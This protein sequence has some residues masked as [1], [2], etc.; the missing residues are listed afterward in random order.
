MARFLPLVVLLAL[1]AAGTVLLLNLSPEELVA[2][3]GTENAYLL[4]F[5]LAFVS[6]LSLF[7]ATPYH[8]VVVTLALGG[9][10][11]W[12]LG[13]TAASAVMAGDS[14]S[15]A[16]GYQGQAVVPP[17]MRSAAQRL[18]RFLRRFP[19]LVPAFFFVYGAIAPFSNDL[20]GVTMGVARYPFVR[21]MVPLALGNLVFNVALAF[22]AEPALQWLS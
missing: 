16:L 14:V 19:R 10:N 5:G 8:L 6:G 9:M 18:Y 12:L 7:G 2:R 15:Y 1:L 3:V 17:R 20:V 11:P 4:L 21:V 13:L 22:L